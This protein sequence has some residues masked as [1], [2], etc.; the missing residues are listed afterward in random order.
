MIRSPNAL[1][2]STH[3]FHYIAFTTICNPQSA[4]FAYL[5]AA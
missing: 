1:L 3:V 5:P 4:I 2:V